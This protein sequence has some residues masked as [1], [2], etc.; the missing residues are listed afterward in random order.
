MHAFSIE[1]WDS[2]TYCCMPVRIDRVA[3]EQPGLS[4]LNAAFFR[5]M[6]GLRLETAR[7]YRHDV[8]RV[9]ESERGWYAHVEIP[10][11]TLSGP[12]IQAAA[13]RGYKALFAL[14]GRAEQFRLVRIWNGIPRINERVSGP[15]DL[16]ELYHYFNLGR[17]EAYQAQF[18]RRAAWPVVAATAIGHQPPVLVMEGLAVGRETET[19]FLENRT[20]IPAFNYSNKYGRVPPLFTRGVYLKNDRHELLLTSGTAAIKGEDSLPLATLQ[21]QLEAAWENVCVLAGR[22]NLQR[23]HLDTA[24]GASALR[25]VQIYY[26]RPEDEEAVIDLCRELFDERVDLRFREADL[27]RPEL[28]VEVEATFSQ[29][30]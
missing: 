21:E 24:F 4:L 8:C 11:S 26:R 16:N 6:L 10:L 9:W 15:D 1:E 27:C 28:L 17:H 23:H 2:K 18:P 13:R 22:P 29:S 25:Q 7:T 19:V 12:N 3:L 20:Q 5:E 14:L 30:V